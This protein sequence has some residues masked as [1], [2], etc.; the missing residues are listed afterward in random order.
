MQIHIVRRR[1]KNPIRDLLLVQSQWKNDLIISRKYNVYL[2]S[3]SILSQFLER[4][5]KVQV[6]VYI[7][8]FPVWKNILVICSS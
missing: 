1:S 3:Y 8:N 6:M 2:S 7:V 4:M 5:V